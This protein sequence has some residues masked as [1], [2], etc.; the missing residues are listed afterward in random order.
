[1]LNQK[2][3]LEEQFSKEIKLQHKECSPS[4][5]PDSP[6]PTPK[7]G[8]GGGVYSIADNFDFDFTMQ[9]DENLLSEMSATSD[10]GFIYANGKTIDVNID[11][12]AFTNKLLHNV[13]SSGMGGAFYLRGSTSASVVVNNMAARNVNA[14]TSGGIAYLD[15]PD[16]TFRFY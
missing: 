6:T 3:D 8:K 7:G 13:I 2:L 4:S 5:A 15:T 9:V 14:A 1:M 16:A 11:A 10:G 12:T